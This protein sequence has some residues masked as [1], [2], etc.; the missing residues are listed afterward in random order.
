MSKTRR[1]VHVLT[2]I[3]ALLALA[4]C[5]SALFAQSVVTGDVQGS[6]TD[7]SGAVVPGAKV[8]LKNPETGFDKTQTTGANGEFRFSLLKP[9]HYTM[10]VSSEKF[11]TVNKQVEVQLGQVTPASV[12]LALGASTTT[13]EVSGEAPLLQTENANMASTVDSRVVQELPNPGGDITFYA[14]IT[15]GVAMNTSGGGYGNFSAYGLPATSNLFT[16]NGNDEN[17]PFLNLNN[18][19]SSNLLLGKNEVQEVAVVTNGYTGQYG[20]QAG[21]AVNYTT[22]SG[23][24]D[25]HGDATWDWNGTAMNANEWFNKQAGNPKPFANSNQWG[26]DFGGPIKKNKTFFYVDTEGL[27]YILPSTQ[28]VYFPTTPF[29]TAIE[30]NIQATSPAQYNWYKQILSQYTSSPAYGKL[31]PYSA[32]PNASSD[33]TGGCGDLAVSGFGAGAAPCLG[34]Y[35]ASG[36]NLNKEWLLTMRVDQNIGNN[37]VVFGRVKLDRG[38]QPTSTDIVN[39]A[40]FSTDS[41]QPSDEGQLN[42]THTFNSRMVNSLVASGLWYSAVFLPDSGQS[43]VLGAL[44]VSSVSFGPNPMSELGGTSVPDY[45]FPQG[46]N[47]TQWQIIDDYSWTKGSHELKF[48]V[49]YRRNDISDYDEQVVTGGFYNFNSMSDFYNGYLNILNGDY[50]FQDFAN[51]SR[52]PVAIYS[53]GLY[54]Q[55]TW[56]VKSNLTLTLALR[57]DRISNPVCQTN[58]F[59]DT[60]S[61]FTTL[62]HDA[63]VPYNQ[64]IDTGLHSAFPGVTTVAWQPR[65]GFSW[66]PSFAHNTVL[67]GGIGLFS[68]LYPAV[69]LDNMIQNP[70]ND[71]GFATYGVGNTVCVAPGVAGCGPALAAA[72]N[73]SFLTGFSSG[74]TLAQIQ[75]GNPFF[76]TPNVFSPASTIKTPMYLEW[77]FMVEQ[78]FGNNNVLSVNYVGNHGYNLLVENTGAN[79]AAG[80]SAITGVPAASIDSRFTE[81]EYLYSGGRSNYDGLISSFTHRFSRGLQFQLN[82]TWSHALDDASSSPFTPFSSAQSISTQI[83]P[84]CLTCQ[85]YGSSD[86]DVRQNFVAD[87]VYNPT[88]KPGNPILNTLFG[89]WQL[90]Q[91]FFLRSGLPYSVTDSVAGTEFNN[92]YGG[93]VLATYLGGGS[94]NGCTSPGPIS[95]PNLCVNA[96]NFAAVGSETTFGNLARNSFRGPGYFN[97]DFNAMKNFSLTERFKLRVGVNM[98]NVFN[99]PNFENPISN[100]ANPAFGQLL[101]TVSPATSPYG[102]FQGAGVSGRLIQTEIHIQF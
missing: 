24:N 79:I 44:G 87:Y 40:V 68:D 74:Q 78:Q 98:F 42:W 83:N 11:S 97:S 5:T 41:I 84:F 65:F 60:S 14:N 94:L 96:N 63:T 49:N 27:R 6:V 67:R 38:S 73:A 72:S 80:T 90:S 4:M 33:P 8:E 36:K 89:G 82:Y 51:A 25:W 64:A 92:T 95:N 21:A 91:T 29:I 19:G 46:R 52:V 57:G 99:H 59:A 20:R 56:K 71:N 62:S 32:S 77:N 9:G 34:Y 16:E 37:D 39:P 22:K 12:A 86:Y 43:A 53:M 31:Q 17:D 45:Y 100:I 85:N 58:C 1:Q 55:D 102:S 61:P 30:N 15:P 70:P 13:V 10:I 35:R 81:A 23:T 93:T 7:P 28:D 50:F 54:A 101:A 69:A 2:L 26:A 75:A 66:N 18:S 76:S 47:V 88:W 3:F 48:G